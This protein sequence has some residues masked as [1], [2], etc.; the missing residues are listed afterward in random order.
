MW[1]NCASKSENH[2]EWRFQPCV[3]IL[4]IPN[5]SKGFQE[6]IYH[7]KDTCM[8]SAVLRRVKW[9]TIRIG[10]QSPVILWQVLKSEKW[11]IDWIWVEV[12]KQ[13]PWIVGLANGGCWKADEQN[14]YE[15]LPSRR[16]GFLEYTSLLSPHLHI[17]WSVPSTLTQGLEIMLVSVFS[18]NHKEGKFAWVEKKSIQKRVNGKKVLEIQQMRS[19]N[20]TVLRGANVK[21]FL[22]LWVS[23]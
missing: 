10:F 20:S 12:A 7:S 23:Y 4:S 21:A 5:F 14:L 13:Y 18:I 22:L 8:V 1:I 15:A 2:L 19:H 3:P 6:R 17:C 16:R 9:R 11:G